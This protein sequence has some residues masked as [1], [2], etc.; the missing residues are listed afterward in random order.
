[1]STDKIQPALAGE[2]ARLRT[3]GARDARVPVIVSIAGVDGGRLRDVSSLE[4]EVRRVQAPAVKRLTELGVRDV[5]PLT[6]ANAIEAALTIDQI[7]AIASE[8]SVV[9]IVWN[10]ME[11]VTAQ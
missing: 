2:M 1:M 5:A 3:S 8:P 10:R 11:R 6:L 7:E 4:A 9:A